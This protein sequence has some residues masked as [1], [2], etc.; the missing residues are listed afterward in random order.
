MIIARPISSR[1]FSMVP[2]TKNLQIAEMVVLPVFVYV[3]NIEH[4]CI[5]CVIT[6]GTFGA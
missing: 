3:V 1:F 4:S 2:N 6:N 5:L